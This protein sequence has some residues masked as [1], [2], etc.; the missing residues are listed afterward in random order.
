MTTELDLGRMLRLTSEDYAYS[1]NIG[2]F[3]GRTS[4]SVFDNKV[5]GAPI[6]K[7]LLTETS[8]CLLKEMT[9]RILKD[10]EVKPIEIG[11]YPWNV[12][13][14]ENIFRSSITIGRDADKC[15]Y[16]DLVGDRHKEPVRLY[17]VTDNS[18]RISGSDVPKQQATELGAR[19]IISAINSLLSVGMVVTK[20]K[21]DGGKGGSKPAGGKPD[22]GSTMG[23]D[24][25]MGTETAVPF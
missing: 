11:Q 16:Y 8:M 5:T 2:V 3:G 1:A 12:D 24:V 17:L 9:E 18:I 10:P 14:K 20:T 22:G 7:A 13:T 15:I 21:W 25:P 19:T 23:D 6:I 4:I